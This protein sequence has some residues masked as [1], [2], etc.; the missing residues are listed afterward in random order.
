MKGH[1]VTNMCL[2][3]KNQSH[4]LFRQFQEDKKIQRVSQAFYKICVKGLNKAGK[5]K[6]FYGYKSK[7]FMQMLN[8]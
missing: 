2:K 1:G 4:C 5:V 7:D 6:I 3:P 8:G